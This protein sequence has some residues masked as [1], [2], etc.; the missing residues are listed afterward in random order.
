[1]QK[2]NNCSLVYNFEKRSGEDSL[3]KRLGNSLLLHRTRQSEND[4]SGP[5]SLQDPSRSNY[6]YRKRRKRGHARFITAYIFRS[7][8]LSSFKGKSQLCFSMV[9]EHPQ[10][11]P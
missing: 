7:F 5:E 6:T 8:F 1:M 9:V 3:E 11:T 2:K 4:T 10:T